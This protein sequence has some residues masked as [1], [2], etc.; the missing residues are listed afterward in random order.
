[1]LGGYHKS[2]IVWSSKYDAFIKNRKMTERQFVKFMDKA[3]KDM[4]IN[5]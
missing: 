1:M 3:S 5:S 2:S 4:M